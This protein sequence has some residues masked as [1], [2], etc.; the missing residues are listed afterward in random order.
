MKKFLIRSSR[1]FVSMVIAAC[2]TSC[3]LRPLV[4]GSL[5][6]T[7]QEYSGDSYD[8]TERSDMDIGLNVA[9]LMLIAPQD[10]RIKPTSFYRQS[11]EYKYQLAYAA[12]PSTTDASGGKEYRYRPS[13][14]YE[15]TGRFID[16]LNL[17]TGLEF[18]QKNSKYE[19]TKIRLSYL[20][21]PLVVVYMHDLGNDRKVF[22][23]LGPY[24]AYGIGGKFEGDGFSE[25]AFD[26]DFG[27]KRFDAG[28][29][30]TGG[31]NFD[32]QW[33]VGLAYD[34]GL[35]NIEQ[36]SFDKTKNR[37]LSVY[38]G[39]SLEKLAKKLGVK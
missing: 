31:Y 27:F 37:C 28:L 39:Y 17:L 16:R 11:Q 23:G 38:V 3:A 14:N 9:V 25:K 7:K 5:D 13:L 18:V 35:T 30:F 34:L 26:Q 15:A 4:R 29:T 33:S 21:V 20:Q 1:V 24:F 32:S 19:E 2:L 10:L 8:E 12:E 36:D 6:F 22:G